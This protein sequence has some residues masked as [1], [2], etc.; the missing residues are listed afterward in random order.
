MQETKPLTI[1][2]GKT[3]L[4]LDVEPPKFIISGFL[5]I[6]LHMLAMHCDGDS[7]NIYG[8][9]EKESSPIGVG[10]TKGGHGQDE[11]V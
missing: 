2:D 6:G 9:I 7:E 3:L 10:L 5:P 4:S 8:G 1:M 11:K